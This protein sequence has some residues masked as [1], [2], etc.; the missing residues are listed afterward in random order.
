MEPD[1]LSEGSED[2]VHDDTISSVG[3]ARPGECDLK[4]LNAW[5]TELLKD[6]VRNRDGFFYEGGGVSLFLD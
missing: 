2:H 1:F 6:Q 3:I 4:K 5:F